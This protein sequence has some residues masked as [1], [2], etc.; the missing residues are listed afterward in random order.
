MKTYHLQKRTPFQY[1]HSQQIQFT[2]NPLTPSLQTLNYPNQNSLNH[3][4]KKH[5]Q[6]SGACLHSPA[7]NTL[8]RIGCY[9]L[10]IINNKFLSP[11]LRS[12]PGPRHALGD[13]KSCFVHYSQVKYQVEIWF[14][15]KKFKV[16]EVGYPEESVMQRL[17][18]T[19]STVCEIS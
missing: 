7:P 14:Q 2:L 12:K 1:H 10:Y 16:Y 9:Y 3:S 13:G 19:G 11:Q 5:T 18:M 6:Q 8:Y 4:P 15:R 17:D